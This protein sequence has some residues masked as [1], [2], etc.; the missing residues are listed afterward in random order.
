MPRP[1]LRPTPAAQ[2][3]YRRCKK[4]NTIGVLIAL[5]GLALL[6]A[7]LFTPKFLA[8]IPLIVGAIMF[9]AGVLLPS[10]RTYTCTAC[11]NSIA[12]QSTLCPTCRR[13]LTKEPTSPVWGF[14]L[15]TLLLIILIFW[16]INS[17]H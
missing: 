3:A 10:R 17:K 13:H 9:L 8:A 6:I 15:I 1:P 11:G 5:L 2:T 16:I 4:D 12:A 7:G 14:L